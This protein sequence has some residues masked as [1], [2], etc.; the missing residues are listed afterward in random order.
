MRIFFRHFSEA[1]FDV[2]M[3]ERNS[4]KNMNSLVKRKR[5]THIRAPIT[6]FRIHFCLNDQ[7]R[8]SVITETS[9]NNN[10]NRRHLYNTQ[11]WLSFSNRLEVFGGQ[12]VLSFF[13]E[14]KFFIQLNSF[15]KFFALQSTD[16]FS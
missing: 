8:I 14:R 3:E 12:S 10:C 13:C 5:A 15:I 1:F 9:F 16:Q 7:H 2:K 6:D 4:N 11:F